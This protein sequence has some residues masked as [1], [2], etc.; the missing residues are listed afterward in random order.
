VTSKLDDSIRRME[1]LRDS[2]DEALKERRQVLSSTTGQNI[3]YEMSI[4]GQIREMSVAR[5]T[6]DEAIEELYRL[7]DLER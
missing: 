5:D 4:A 6:V 3:F 2:Y 7:K 1:G